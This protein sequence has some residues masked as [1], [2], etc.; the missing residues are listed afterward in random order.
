MKN[1]GNSK[2]L[3]NTYNGTLTYLKVESNGHI[4]ILVFL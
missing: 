4:F 1:L 2:V 3:E